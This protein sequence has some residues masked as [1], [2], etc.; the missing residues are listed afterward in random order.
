MPF[1]RHDF[2][3]LSDEGNNN[4]FYTRYSD[5]LSHFPAAHLIH[6]NHDVAT[7]T[8]F[9]QLFPK[10]QIDLHTGQA[11]VTGSKP[12]AMAY[13]GHQFGQWAGQLGDGRALL[14]AQAA[15]DNGKMWDIQIKGGGKTAYSRMG[16]GY[17][18][19]RSTLREY[20]ACFAMQ[21]LG[22][23]TTHALS[24]CTTGQK[25]IREEEEDGA[26]LIR[27]SQSFIRFGHFEHFYYRNDPQNLKKLCDYTMQQMGHDDPQSW[28]QDV[29]TRTAHL[30]AAWQAVGFCH[31]VLNTDN[32]SIIGESLDYGPYGFMESYDPDWICNQSDY[33]GRYR[34]RN[35]PAIGLW[36][37][38]ALAVALSPIIPLDQSMLILKEY[39]PCLN[40]AYTNHLYKKF[41]FIIG[42][43]DPVI[44]DDLLTRFMQL[45]E[46]HR[47]DYTRS[48]S[49][50]DDLDSLLKIMNHDPNAIVWM[51]DYESLNITERQNPHYIARNWVLQKCIESVQNGDIGLLESLIDILKSPYD[52]HHNFTHYK[53][54]APL[55]YA[56][57]RVSCSS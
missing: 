39:M 10:T 37:L 31:G 1:L 34:F 24:I 22:I 16:D 54:S 26:V 46:N 28:F 43:H 3:A 14:L 41:G 57:L 5:S 44:I 35:Q 47:A 45:L 27:L 12:L 15:D 29:M 30:I 49:A 33:Q 21:G 52:P 38:Q 40:T 4:P 19:L 20:L 32:M 50:L 9:D 8:G 17:A 25:V 51:R 18:V 42:T 36:N 56:G 2:A 6:Y 48:F 11:F 23:P 7:Q 55:D 53:N 13:S